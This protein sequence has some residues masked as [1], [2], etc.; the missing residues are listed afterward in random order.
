MTR[1]PVAR[2]DAIRRHN[3]GMLLEQ[4]HRDGDL[5]RAELTQRL[6]LSRSTI[7]ALAADLS[8]LGLVDE[9]VPGGGDRA[10]RPSHV[11]GP[12]TDGSY[13]VAVDVDI[14]RVTTAAVG[15]GGH[16]L[17]RHVVET[18]AS[19]PTSEAVA[20]LIVEAA[21]VLASM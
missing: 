8:D 18:P 2:P 16:V 11:V 13:A 3:L 21:E 4:I 17:A 14:A 10:G 9:R 12:R 19:P 1:V 6:H 15:I 7:G 5:T 20:R